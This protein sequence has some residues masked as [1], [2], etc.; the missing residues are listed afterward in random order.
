MSMEADE[1][2]YV[3]ADVSRWNNSPFNQTPTLTGQASKISQ[4]PHSVPPLAI[5]RASL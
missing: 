1:R 3:A 5:L 2:G 4:T